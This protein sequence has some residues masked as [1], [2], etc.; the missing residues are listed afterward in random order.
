MKNY[1]RHRRGMTLLIV[2]GVLAMLALFA[3][4]IA[5]I[6]R[7]ERAASANFNIRQQAGVVAQSALAR[8]RSELLLE[9]RR[10][11]FSTLVPTSVRQ[12]TISGAWMFR[13]DDGTKTG[14]GLVL[15]PALRAF[16]SLKTTVTVG[17]TDITCSGSYGSTLTKFGDIAFM[18]VLDCASQLNVRGGQASLPVMLYH[19]G[20]ALQRDNG[21]TENPLPYDLALAIVARCQVG[22]GP[23]IAVDSKQ[24]LR[25]LLGTQYDVLIDYLAIQGWS[26]AS[27]MSNLG[28][29][30]PVNGQAYPNTVQ[31]GYER[32]YPINI[33]S[34]PRPVLTALLA[35]LNGTL[36]IKDLPDAGRP[37]VRSV[38]PA[39]RTRGRTE[40]ADGGPGATIDFNR[41]Y[42]L[43]TSII[44]R[45][46]T[47]PFTGWA[48][49]RGF[50]TA[51]ATSADEGDL[52]R[53]ALCS[54]YVAYETHPN[55]GILERLDK[56]HVFVEANVVGHGNVRATGGTTEICFSPMGFV[57]VEVLARI[58]NHAGF[59]ATETRKREVLQYL[60]VY[61]HD[62]QRAFEHA[63]RLPDGNPRFN[64]PNGLGGQVTDFK[65]QPATYRYAKTYPTPTLALGSRS[66]HPFAGYVL[67]G[68]DQPAASRNGAQTFS[69]LFEE[70]IEADQAR[71]QAAPTRNS[72]NFTPQRDG[73]DLLPDGLLCIENQVGDRREIEYASTNVDAVRGAAEFWIKLHTAPDIG[74]DEVLLYVSHRLARR[75]A[76]PKENNLVGQAWRLERFGTQLVSTRFFWGSP[77]ADVQ[78]APT[79]TWTE[80][81]TDISSWRAHE[82]HHLALTWDAGIIP[83]EIYVDGTLAAR[84]SARVERRVD[85]GVEG[86][87]YSNRNSFATGVRNFDIYIF[88]LLS[89]APDSVFQFGG[90]TFDQAER[91]SA[92][93][94]PVSAPI[95]L[96]DQDSSGTN[97]VIRPTSVEPSIERFSTATL[98]DLRFY[99]DPTQIDLS[100]KRFPIPVAPST[101]TS[102][103]GDHPEF[104]G[105]FEFHRHGRVLAMMWD[106]YLPAEYAG[107]PLAKEEY[108]LDIQF[109]ALA[110]GASTNLPGFGS[111]FTSLRE[112]LGLTSPTQPWRSATTDPEFHGGYWSIADDDA[113][114]RTD[115]LAYSIKLFGKPEDNVAPALKLVEVHVEE[116]A[117]TFPY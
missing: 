107:Q 56:A 101:L 61:R 50:V 116:P 34:A 102:D 78:G 77:E 3:G 74:S 84:D 29:L 9:S 88:L 8:L 80:A 79:Y 114:R 98:D 27:A 113:N 11:P 28:I 5:T 95:E 97:R 72:R 111:A 20:L 30:D 65:G 32:R 17:S 81:R 26:E 49:F 37:A 110:A 58:L 89:N 109:Q 47:R 15:D 10:A 117:R 36:R 90:Y 57:E 75:T 66:A 87:F 76:P 68:P 73:G 41:A 103:D 35:G 2:L 106:F 69:A 22:N 46:N 18:K 83:Q 53:T 67:L 54:F 62:T 48:D 93:A 1:V 45:R 96:F 19:L 42:D 55:K 7:I 100:P 64:F 70:K 38:R 25:D 99:S 21:L 59:I 94:A 91:S 13:N 43:A 71:N 4:A 31:L 112:R 23:N 52:L 24:D 14:H 40:T 33:N 104:R 92:D 60:T 82:W 12:G 86:R 115:R 6:T 39:K 63:A 16:P 85:R 108:L 105:L 51:N 44:T